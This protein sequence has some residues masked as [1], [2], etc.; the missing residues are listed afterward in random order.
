L[1]GNASD[2]KVKETVEEIFTTF[3]HLFGLNTDQDDIEADEEDIQSQRLDLTQEADKEFNDRFGLLD[4]A[5]QVA[6]ESGVSYF[7]IIEH[8]SIHVLALSNYLIEKVKKIER[9]NKHNGKAK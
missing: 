9:E 4:L 1:G 7:E 5:M 2:G 3:S 6:K 8:P